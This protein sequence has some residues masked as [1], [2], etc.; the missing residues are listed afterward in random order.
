MEFNFRIRIDISCMLYRGRGNALDSMFVLPGFR[1]LFPP[2]AFNF[3]DLL[4]A[5][6][7]KK[8]IVYLQKICIK[9]ILS[10]NS[11]GTMQLLEFV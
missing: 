6:T 5:D 9:L 3:P 2:S 1:P 11:A 4:L 10:Y 7:E 8:I